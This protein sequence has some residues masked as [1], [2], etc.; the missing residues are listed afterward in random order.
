MR[1]QGGLSTRRSQQ[2]LVARTTKLAVLHGATVIV[3]S[4]VK[5]LCIKLCV[6]CVDVELFHRLMDI[7]YWSKEFFD[8]IIVICVTKLPRLP[9]KF[10][11]HDE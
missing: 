2:Q 8:L 5:A 7:S 1:L 11:F 4:I 9:L 6:L 10:C 3:V